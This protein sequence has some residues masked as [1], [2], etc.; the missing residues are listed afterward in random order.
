MKKLNFALIATITSLIF[1]FSEAHAQEAEIKYNHLETPTE[2]WQ[3]EEYEEYTE[4]YHQKQA[5]LEPWIRLCQRKYNFRTGVING[6]NA[7]AQC[8]QLEMRWE[9]ERQKAKENKE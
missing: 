4:N 5:R 8:I 1:A 9:L 6:D 7:I 2:I 3:G